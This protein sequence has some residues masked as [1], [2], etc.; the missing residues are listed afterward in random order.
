MVSFSNLINLDNKRQFLLD[1][2]VIRE[3]KIHLSKWKRF[4]FHFR[5]IDCHQFT[6]IS[7]NVPAIPV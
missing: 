1:L 3:I 5:P 7:T 2:P 6:Q 4:S